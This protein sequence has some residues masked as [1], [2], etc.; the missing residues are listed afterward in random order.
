VNA[1]DGF[2]VTYTATNSNG[3]PVQCGA[4]IIYQMINNAWVEVA[5][6]AAPAAS[7]T[8]AN[9]Q[10]TGSCAYEFR[11]GFDPGAGSVNGTN[12]R[13][14]YNGVDYLTQAS[15]CVEVRR[16]C[17]SEFTITAA[18]IVVQNMGNGVYE[19]TIKYI[20]TSPVDVSNVKFQGGATAGGNANHFYITDFGNTQVVHNN[21]NNTVLQWN[22]NL[23]ACTP[24][25]VYFKYRRN[26]SCPATGALVTGNW[27]A[28][29]AGQ[30]LGTIL[31]LPYSC[32]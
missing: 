13:G 3:G 22:G 26:F 10:Q 7:V 9:A 5:R 11:A 30:V 6:A 23:T 21:N 32:Q 2:T 27:S 19:F 15:F 20:L 8:I 1:G 31:P 29:T 25:E 18:P 12:C 4:V 28:S 14:L 17:V 24:Q 16:A